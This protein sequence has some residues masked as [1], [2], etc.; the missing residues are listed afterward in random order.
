MYVHDAYGACYYF[1]YEHSASMT[2]ERGEMDG[3]RK[4]KREREGESGDRE[5]EILK[6]AD[7]HV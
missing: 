4:R 2:R 7:T 5:R 6:S 3:E 1:L